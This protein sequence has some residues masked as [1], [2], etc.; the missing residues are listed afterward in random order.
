[1]RNTKGRQIANH[2]IG[3][4][5]VNSAS[6]TPRGDVAWLRASAL[7]ISAEMREAGALVLEMSG[8]LAEGVQSADDLICEQIFR[9]MAAASTSVN[10]SANISKFLRRARRAR[11]NGSPWPEHLQSTCPAIGVVCGCWPVCASGGQGQ[12]TMALDEARIPKF[13]EFSVQVVQSRRELFDCG[14]PSLCLRQQICFSIQL[15]NI[16]LFR[17]K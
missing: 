5:V 7:S 12:S 9:A 10:T 17:P 8:R 3:A 13:L 1:V 4:P 6:P 15:A 16:P 2:K 14:H 11:Q